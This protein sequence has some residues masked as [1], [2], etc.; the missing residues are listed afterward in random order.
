MRPHV[1]RSLQVS[2]SGRVILCFGRHL[3]PP[4]NERKDGW[5][6]KINYYGQHITVSDEIAEFLEQDRR[7]EAAQKRGDRRHINYVGMDIA[8]IPD[9]FTNEP[10]DPTFEKAYRNLRMGALREAYKDLSD[11]ERK[12]L[13]WYYYHEYTMEEIGEK[14]GVSKMAVSKRLRK[15]LDRLRSLM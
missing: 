1:F 3:R 12:L 13:C 7:R 15:I 5:M 10:S 2:G 11:E 8:S 6:K 14:L 9:L 4:L